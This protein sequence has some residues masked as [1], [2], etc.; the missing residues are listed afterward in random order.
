MPD[1]TA[2]PTGQRCSEMQLNEYDNREWLTGGTIT[3]PLYGGK[4]KKKNTV[5]LELG[6]EAIISDARSSE[7]KLA[8]SLVFDPGFFL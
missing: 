5:R 8:S 7:A 2:S 4:K 3:G 6:S 1:L